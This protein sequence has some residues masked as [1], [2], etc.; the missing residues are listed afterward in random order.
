MRFWDA[1]AIV[2]LL[3]TESATRTVQALAAKDSAMLVWWA[4]EVECAS[5]VARLDPGI[6]GRS[7]ID[8]CDDLRDL[9]FERQLDTDAAELAARDR[10]HLLVLLLIHI[11]GMRIEP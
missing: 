11:I 3:M 10:R 7:A 2:P 8:R 9:G 6:R 5:A 4:T 1:S